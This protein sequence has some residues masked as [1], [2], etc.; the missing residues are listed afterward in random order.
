MSVGRMCGAKVPTS[1]HSKTRWWA[2][3]MNRVP[4]FNSPSTTRT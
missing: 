1:V 3:D 4:A 2:I